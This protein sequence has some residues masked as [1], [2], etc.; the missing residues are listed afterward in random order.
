M[1]EFPAA[2][3]FVLAH[4]GGQVN[5]PDDPG[6]A[7]NF[8]VTQA[9]LD[10]WNE[11]HPEAAF[12]ASVNDLSLDQASAIYRADYW[13]FDGLDEQRVATKLLDMAVNM[14]LGTAVKLAQE[15]LNDLGACLRVDGAYGPKTEATINSVG[16]DRMLALLC[17]ASADHYQALA[18]WRPAS[19]KFLKGWLKRAAEV[20]HP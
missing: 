1:A 17:A 3:P 15:A 9:T 16:A 6:G 2:L 18:A 13:R 5:D 8:G 14:G 20:P 7:T 11:K 4:E 10:R 12:P 19:R